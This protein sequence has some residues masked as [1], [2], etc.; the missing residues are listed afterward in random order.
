MRRQEGLDRAAQERRVVAG[1][2]RHDQ[3][4][5]LRGAQRPGELAVEM[6]ETAERL[7]P[8]GL[9]LDRGADAA[10]LGIVDAPFRLAVAARGALEQF[11]G[12]GDR[13]AHFGV[14][15]RVQRILKQDFRG[16]RHRARRIERGVRHF[17][18]PV[19][20][21]RQCRTAFARQ[22]RCPAKLT[23]RHRS[24]TPVL[25]RSIVTNA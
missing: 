13:L 11:A 12:R 18:H 15:P 10:H 2:R 25:R 6:Q 16:V 21:R 24:Q 23:N 14:R 9:D 17:V 3:H 20:R 1:H 7:F 5:R 19:H 22:R 8:D 4:P